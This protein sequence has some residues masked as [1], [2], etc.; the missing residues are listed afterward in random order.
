LFFA[1]LGEKT[2]ARAS[3]SLS[4]GTT[5]NLERRSHSWR[6]A[7]AHLLFIGT[8][9]AV[10]VLGYLPYLGAGRSLFSGLGNYAALWEANDSIFRLVRCAGN[11]QRPAEVVVAVL[12]LGLLAYVIG[13]A[14]PAETWLPL[15]ASQAGILRG[16]FILIAALLLLSPN[17][18]PWYFTWS[19]PFL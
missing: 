17:A 19:I 7:Q 11:S 13:S 6:R 1:S 4:A 9:A 8:F 18:F 16:S 10:V 14:R 5:V 12:L 2:P 15:E 3:A